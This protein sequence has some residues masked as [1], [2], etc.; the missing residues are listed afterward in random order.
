MESDS[1]PSIIPSTTSATSPDSLPN[2]QIVACTSNEH[3]QRLQLVLN[4]LPVFDDFIWEQVEQIDPNVNAR[5]WGITKEANPEASASDG[6]M[7]KTNFF[8]LV[9]TN[10]TLR[11]KILY[12]VVE[13]EQEEKQEV[14][15]F[16]M[17]DGR[18]LVL[19]HHFLYLDVGATKNWIGN[20]ASCF[21]EDPNDPT[22]VTYV[23]LYT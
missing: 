6:S 4:R 9:G 23:Y 13:G 10:E 14:T 16:E 15:F 11:M 8:W 18:T 21:A 3:E 7:L 17:K 5:A 2:L 20:M 1:V 12:F 19:N 22:I